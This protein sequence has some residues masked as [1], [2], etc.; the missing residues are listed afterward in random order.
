M[1][2]KWNPKTCMFED[3]NDTNDRDSFFKPLYQPRMDILKI[4]PII[5]E[6]IRPIKIEP[7]KIFDSPISTFYNSRNAESNSDRLFREQQRRLDDEIALKIYH[8]SMANWI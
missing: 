2:G 5:I 7:L 8:T 3:N 6:P 4:E 1:I